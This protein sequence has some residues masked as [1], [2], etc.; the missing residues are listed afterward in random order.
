MK[1]TPKPGHVFVELLGATEDTERASGIVVPTVQNPEEQH[2]GRIVAVAAFKE[3][4]TD[5][6]PGCCSNCVPGMNHAP[7]E[8]KV[9]QYVIFKRHHADVFAVRDRIFFN[10]RED[11]LLA[12][13][14]DEATFQSVTTHDQ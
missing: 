10:V 2:K 14:D 12:V 3:V 5:C 1:I 7:I 6:C 13:T 9:G 8:S 4:P 11:D